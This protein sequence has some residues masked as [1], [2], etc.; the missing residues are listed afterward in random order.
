MYRVDF[1]SGVRKP[2]TPE[3]VAGTFASISPDGKWVAFDVSQGGIAVYPLEGGEPRSYPGLPNPTRQLF[4]LNFTSDGK[5]LFVLGR[6]GAGGDAYVLELATGKWSLW[7]QLSS[8]E[9]LGILDFGPALVT[10]DGKSYA[11]SYRQM[12]STLFLVTGLGEA[13]Q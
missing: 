1:Q 3:G 5:Q 6:G 4:P 12:L 2:V 13:P 7:K 9:R 10:P 11:Y 8:S